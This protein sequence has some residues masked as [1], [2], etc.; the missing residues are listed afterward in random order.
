MVFPLPMHRLLINCIR[1]IVSTC[2]QK[3]WRFLSNLVVTM[4]EKTMDMGSEAH[5][6]AGHFKAAWSTR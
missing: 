2:R 3:T 6:K 4:I 5:G 1:N